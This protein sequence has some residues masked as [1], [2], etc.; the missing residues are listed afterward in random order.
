[1]YDRRTKKVK[2]GHFLSERTTM[3]CCVWLCT[4]STCSLSPV[5]SPSVL[6]RGQATAVPRPYVVWVGGCGF[7]YENE[8]GSDRRPAPSLPTA[9]ITHGKYNNLLYMYAVRLFIVFTTIMARLGYAM[10]AP[11]VAAGLLGAVQDWWACV[12]NTMVV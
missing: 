10:H 1:M 2:K 4:Y 8:N 6:E 3:P 11:K 7:V 5:H 9:L 12:A